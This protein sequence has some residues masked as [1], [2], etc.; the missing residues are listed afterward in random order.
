MT[1]MREP[2]TKEREKK[3]G[4]DIFSPKTKA[5]AYSARKTGMESQKKKEKPL[6]FVC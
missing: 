3:V 1:E 6:W 4:Q 2:R 5:N